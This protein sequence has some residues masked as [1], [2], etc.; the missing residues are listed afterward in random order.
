M[1]IQKRKDS[2]TQTSFKERCTSREKPVYLWCWTGWRSAPVTGGPVR[3]DPLPAVTMRKRLGRDQPCG[4]IAVYTPCCA[5]PSQQWE[6]IRL[7][8]RRHSLST[9][10]SATVN[11]NVLLP[12]TRHFIPLVRMRGKEFHTLFK[13]WLKLFVLVGLLQLL[14]L[15]VIIWTA[16]VW[17]ACNLPLL[18]KVWMTSAHL[19]L[20]SGWELPVQLVW[21]GVLRR[22]HRSRHSLQK[23]S[24]GGL[25]HN[26]HNPIK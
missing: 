26:L 14:W 22:F 10:W 24:I 5:S 3:S 21:L 2:Q 4:G 13:I 19:P 20:A 17:W 23:A 1:M 11:L 7:K 8:E 25:R 15:I 6:D 18:Q 16:L 12:W 9:C